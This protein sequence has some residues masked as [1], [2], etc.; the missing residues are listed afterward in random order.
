MEVIRI[1][2]TNR[3]LIPSMSFG[4]QGR[5]VLDSVLILTEVS[6]ELINDQSTLS[7]KSTR[8]R[9]DPV[10]FLLWKTACSPVSMGSSDWLRGKHFFLSQLS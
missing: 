8:V 3:Y 10:S 1:K 9:L 7:N 2:N 6:A 5:Q 4:I